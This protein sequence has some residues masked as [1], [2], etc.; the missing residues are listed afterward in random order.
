MQKN[1]DSSH[2]C[3]SCQDTGYV[4]F[5]KKYSDTKDYYTTAMY[6]MCIRGQNLSD[7]HRAYFRKKRDEA[8]GKFKESE[9]HDN[10]A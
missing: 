3:E 7:G 4:L 2:D 1:Q 8:E 6:C 5:E 10:P 9:Y